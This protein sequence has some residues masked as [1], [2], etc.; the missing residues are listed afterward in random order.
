[1]EVSGLSTETF[2]KGETETTGFVT[3]GGKRYRVRIMRKP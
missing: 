2:W 3:D 1:M